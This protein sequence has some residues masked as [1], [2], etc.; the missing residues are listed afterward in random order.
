MFETRMTY[1]RPGVS[2]LYC[3][4]EGPTT[5]INLMRILSIFSYNVFDETK[6]TTLNMA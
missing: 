2:S 3:P 5:N 1:V 6:I 4:F